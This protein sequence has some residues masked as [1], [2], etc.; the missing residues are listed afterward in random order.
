MAG[1]SLGYAYRLSMH[2]RV[3]SN[4][5]GS[6]KRWHGFSLTL[7]L[8]QRGGIKRKPSSVA[9]CIRECKASRMREDAAAL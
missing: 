1:L 8:F 9:A 7:A 3:L 5:A 6:W 2:T 4:V